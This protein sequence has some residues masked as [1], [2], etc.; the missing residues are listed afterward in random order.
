MQWDYQ[1]NKEDV[2]A[3]VPF[4]IGSKGLKQKNF[5]LLNGIPLWERAARQGARVCSTVIC[6]SD[7]ADLTLS[8]NGKAIRFDQR[9]TEL[10]QDTSE[11]RD[12]IH[13]LIKKFDLLQSTILLLQPTSPLRSDRS[14]KEALDLYA[15]GSWSMV[16][17]VKQV[18]NKVLKYG[19]DN[20]GTFASINEPSYCFANRQELP[21][22]V[23][24]NGAI[25]IF[26]A[27]TFLDSDGFPSENI[28]IYEMDEI[29]SFDLDTKVDLENVES[30]LKLSSP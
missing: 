6:S 2:V 19:F 11:I 14:I 10:A 15:H 12:V 24:P 18:S 4:R 28:G 29:E 27:K 21:K 13:H 9:P 16:M 17:S 23:G 3:L 22:V 8:V 20:N 1:M 7:A 5:R 26:S 30:L 25:Y